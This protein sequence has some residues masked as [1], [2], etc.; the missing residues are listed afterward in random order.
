[1]LWFCVPY[2]IFLAA[3]HGAAADHGKSRSP[4][5]VEGPSDASVRQPEW[6]S[7]TL[8]NGSFEMGFWGGRPDYW[9][10]GFRNEPL[11]AESGSIVL[12]G[13][14]ATHGACS[15]QLTAH[16]PAGGFFISQICDG[17]ANF[18]SDHQVEAS[19]DVSVDDETQFQFAVFAVNPEL[20]IDPEWGIGLAGK[21]IAVVG[22]TQGE[23]QSVAIGFEAVGDATA[24]AVF[25]LVSG[26]G[27]V[28]IDNASVRWPQPARR[29]MPD[30]PPVSPAFS[31][32]TF[33]WGWVNE[34]PANLSH[35]ADEDLVSR[36]AAYHGDTLNL[37]CHVR[38]NQLQGRALLGGFETPLSQASRAAELGVTR[39][40]TFDF[41]HDSLDGIGLLNPMPDGTSPGTLNDPNV[42]QAMK[43]ECLAL[44]EAIQPSVV[45]V[46]IEIDFFYVNSPKQWEAFVTWYRD[47]RHALKAL[48]PGCLVS[49]YVTLES[50]VDRQGRLIEP[51]ISIF[52]S[53]QGNLDL[54]CYS[55][56]FF[57][58][59]LRDGLLEPEMF[60]AIG[61]LDPSLSIAIPEFGIN[62]ELPVPSAPQE[63][64]IQ[65]V[66]FLQEILD[67]VAER[68]CA[69]ATLYSCLDQTYFGVPFFQT[70]FS[71]IGLHDFAG[72]PK[73]SAAWFQIVG[74]M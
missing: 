47:V 32:R 9:D 63:D 7:Q 52:A 33:G 67:Q 15:L 55:A 69:F 21:S 50:V 43:A 59:E 64:Q 57:W 28:W 51:G 25:C 46:G 74:N 38:Y 19:I 39:I 29:L 31:T 27:S 72:S 10:I 37:F 70:H 66:L 54:L 36:L 18:L 14:R 53:L 35:A 23:F 73:P 1:M 61:Q 20:P 45:L 13:S 49:I 42:R 30:P 4:A 62:T 58:N 12:D 3:C 44:A 48:D 60:S 5:K 56:Y 71:H 11:P 34:N 26:A 6:S 22:P 68:G 2:W 8:H 40:L 65:Q 24:V 16:D 41:T 17:N